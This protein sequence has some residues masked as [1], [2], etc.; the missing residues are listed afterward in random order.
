MQ[1]EGDRRRRGRR[2]WWRRNSALKLFGVGVVLMLVLIAV[3]WRSLADHAPS[4][5]VLATVD[6]VEVTLEDV[7]AEGRAQSRDGEAHDRRQELETVISRILL[8]RAARARGLDR[9]AAF[10]ADRARAEAQLLAEELIG[11]TGGSRA[12]DPSQLAAYVASHPAAFAQ[13]RMDVLDRLTWTQTP[14]PDP[15]RGWDLS[16][17]KS[18]LDHS[19]V[20][21]AEAQISVMTDELASPLAAHLQTSAPGSAVLI[22]DG[23]RSTAFSV[24]SAAPAPIVGPAALWRARGLLE[25]D[26][27]REAVSDMINAL[28]RT[29]AIR[30]QRGNGPAVTRAQGESR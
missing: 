22:R 29:S 2:S 24:V 21:Y 25:R 28:R 15:L 27:Q 18:D 16:S 20:R 12:P 14:S 8:A 30:Y 9:A 3:V 19:G 10:P 13:R 5:Q 4:G 7:Q 1:Q 6:G 17:L 26:M 11:R 23:D